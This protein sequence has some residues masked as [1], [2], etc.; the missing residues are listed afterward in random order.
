MKPTADPNHDGNSSKYHTGKPCS[1]K[2]CAE[3][4]G[5]WWGPSWC[6]KHNHERLERIGAT[7]EDMAA[8]A[9]LRAE[10]ERETALLRKIANRALADLR[11]VV[12]AVGGRV[13][14][15]PEHY[16]AE[17][18]SES[19]HTPQGRAGPRTYNYMVK[20]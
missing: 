1:V 13:T 17:I 7:L 6:Q 4:A 15:L 14:V 8:R 16:S 9:A 18:I 2:G 10:I 5:T 19:V 3:P 11:A 20:R 12:V